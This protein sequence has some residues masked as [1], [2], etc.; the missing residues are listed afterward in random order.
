MVKAE[1]GSNG[2][3]PRGYAK[4]V[5]EWRKEKELVCREEVVARLVAEEAARMAAKTKTNK[6]F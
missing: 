4:R 1:Y 6:M 2:P 5:Q 3:R